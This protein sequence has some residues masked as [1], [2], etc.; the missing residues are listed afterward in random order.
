MGILDWLG[1]LSTA[2]RAPYEL[3]DVRADAQKMQYYEGPRAA[4]TVNTLISGAGWSDANETTAQRNAAVYACLQ[5][6]ATAFPE[7]PLRVY[8]QRGDTRAPEPTSPLQLLLDRPNAHMSAEQVL[9]WTVWALHCDGN[10]YWRKLRNGRSAV[11]ELWPISPTRVEPRTANPGDFIS[12]YRYFYEPGKFV[13]LA[14]EDVVHFRLG[15]D[16]EDHRR[17]LSPL[18]R[19]VRHVSSDDNATKFADALLRNFAVPGLVVQ[20]P[21]DA[22]LTPEDAAELKASVSAAYGAEN[23]GNVGVLT[24]GATMQALGFSPEQMDLKSL[25]RIPEERIAAVLG[26]P[27][28]VAGLGAGLDRATYSNVREAREMFTESKLVPL[29]RSV[30]ATLDL[31][32]VP[33][34]ASSG[35]SV[36]FDLAEVRALADDQTARF[37]RL[38]LAVQGGWLTADEAR[39]Q[40][41]LPPLPAPTAVPLAVPTESRAALRVLHRKA[42]EDLPQDLLDLQEESIYDWDQRVQRYLRDRAKAIAESIRA[43]GGTLQWDSELEVAELRDV[44]DPAKLALLGKVNNLVAAQLGIQFEL[45]DPLTREF[46][47]TSGAQIQGITDVTRSEIQEALLAGQAEFESLRELTDRILKLGAFSA[48]RARVIARTEL[49]YATNAAALANYRASGVV[50]GVTVYDGDYDAACQAMNGTTYPLD[51][52]PPLL[53]HPNCRRAFGPLLAGD[54]A[55][56]SA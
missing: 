10:A 37:E 52:A 47:R 55:R 35:L 28:I 39:E 20:V 25:H 34:F 1:P 48:A 41:G 22:R 46:L 14:P 51:K 54:E 53:Q 33:D 21:A 45:D 27:A 8:R 49:G 38:N 13:D 9:A 2:R 7:P 23:R 18:K 30:A 12:Y 31:Q 17:G 44:L 16:D 19:L 11:V 5:A 6:L 56:I 26:V 43:N 50:I 36:A 4:F 24:G 15:L 29:W 32:L 3:G 40:I 42:A